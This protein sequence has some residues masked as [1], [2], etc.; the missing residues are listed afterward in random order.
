MNIEKP[1]IISGK[2]INIIKDD[3]VH[4]LRNNDDYYDIVY[5][6]PPYNER[7]YAPNF[8]VLENLSNNDYPKLKGI[9]GI[10]EY[11]EQKSNFCYRKKALNELISVLD[12]V[13]TNVFLLSYSTEG[14]M[15]KNEI[16]SVLL[17][18]FKNVV[19]ESNEYRRFKTNSNTNTN[20]GLCE[21]LFI[22]YN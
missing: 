6:D 13:K 1:I 12:L 8:H 21:L 18:Y 7:Q 14:I 3:I 4:F 17:R 2:K 20:T 19:I 10:I 5:L 22:A 9:T 15:K 11:Q 16:Q